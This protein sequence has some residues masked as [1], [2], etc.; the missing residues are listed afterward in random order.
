[1]SCTCPY[2]FEQKCLW[3]LYLVL[4]WFENTILQFGHIIWCR[5]RLGRMMLFCFLVKKNLHGSV[6][7]MKCPSWRL[8]DAFSVECGKTASKSMT[9][10]FSLFSCVIFDFTVFTWPSKTVYMFIESLWRLFCF[11]NCSIWLI[12]IGKSI[13]EM[14]NSLSIKFS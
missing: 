4:V 9:F 11:T 6:I 14:S 7:S 10:G 5:R 12:L 3:F 2:W 1:M 8:L 13:P